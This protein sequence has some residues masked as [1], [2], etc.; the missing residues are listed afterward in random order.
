MEEG[1]TFTSLWCETCVD[2]WSRNARGAATCKTKQ[3][4]RKMEMNI[5]RI[6]VKTTRGG[7]IRNQDV[8]RQCEIT[9]IEKFI[10]RR[11]RDFKIVFLQQ[12]IVD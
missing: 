1:I 4:L 8:R 5:L 6:I 11:K 3:L 10:K 7:I 9:D 2:K 12:T